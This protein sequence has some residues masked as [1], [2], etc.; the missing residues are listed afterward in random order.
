MAALAI[1]Y[2]TTTP[3][4]PGEFGSGLHGA[5]GGAGTPPG[6]ELQADRGPEESVTGAG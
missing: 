1:S 6:A 2:N 5:D 4:M 3:T